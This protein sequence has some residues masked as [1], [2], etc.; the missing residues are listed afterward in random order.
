MSFDESTV[1]SVRP[2][3]HLDMGLQYFLEFNDVQ[4][5]LASFQTMPDGLLGMIQR[6]RSVNGETGFID[7]VETIKPLD[8]FTLDQIKKIAS[9]L[10]LARQKSKADYLT[11]LNEVVKNQL[12]VVIHSGS[13]RIEQQQAK[14][15]NNSIIVMRI[16]G[17]CVNFCKSSSTISRIKSSLKGLNA[18]YMYTKRFSLSLYFLKSMYIS[19][20]MKIFSKVEKCHC[21]SN[22]SKRISNSWRSASHST[23]SKR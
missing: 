17:I 19:S 4:E 1:G 11:K 15:Y 21:R 6:N 2:G 12:E 5:M 8:K 7:T 20:R 14:L 9:K 10:G 23:L 3:L 16:I 13:T 18:S 22:S